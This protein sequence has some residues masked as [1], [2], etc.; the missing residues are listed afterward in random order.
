MSRTVHTSL[1]ALLLVSLM[2]ALGSA[3]PR[4]SI[5]V[6]GGLGLPEKS[7]IDASRELVIPGND[8]PPTNF[9]YVKQRAS[10]AFGARIGVWP[11]ARFGI[12]GEV[13]VLPSRGDLRAA[14]LNPAD[15]SVSF[16]IL[17]EKATSTH[18]GLLLSYAIVQPALDP[19]LVYVSAGV[20]AT[21]RSGA[22]FED[23]L[24]LNTGTDVGGVVGLGI[25]Y[26][27]SP[28]MAIRTDLRDYITTYDPEVVDAGDFYTGRTQHDLILSA[29]IDFT[30]LK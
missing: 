21:R 2:P 20:G 8:N 25:S 16:G 6:L 12:E 24:E 7:L 22:L 1:A 29:G 23:L 13:V 19:I 10:V 26:G 14:F 27:L 15:D 4:V 17:D 9:V 18:F 3:A 11:A 28:N 30:L 5:G